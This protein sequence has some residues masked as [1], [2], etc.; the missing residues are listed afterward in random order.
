[1]DAILSLHHSN[2]IHRDIKPANFLI[3]DLKGNVNTYKIKIIDFA[4]SYTKN[5]TNYNIDYACSHPYSP[6]ECIDKK[7]FN[8]KGPM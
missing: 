2:V 4:E 5:I 6:F 8:E 3:D 1:V 7:G